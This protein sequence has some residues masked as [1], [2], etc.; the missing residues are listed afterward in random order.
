MS[1]LNKHPTTQARTSWCAALVRHYHR[2]KT[3][4]RQ[5][6]VA[7]LVTISALSMLIALISQFTFGTTVAGNR[8]ASTA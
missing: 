4:D 8:E 3:R 1:L 2:R 5:S 7:L 6:G